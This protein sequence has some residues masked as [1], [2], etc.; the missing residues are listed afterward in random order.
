MNKAQLVLLSTVS[1]E[2][3][4]EKGRLLAAQNLVNDAEARKRCEERFGIEACKRQ[5]PEA[6]SRPSLFK[7][8]LDRLRYARWEEFE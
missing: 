4:M 7:R 2:F 6:Y 8:I 3:A 5:W 1:D